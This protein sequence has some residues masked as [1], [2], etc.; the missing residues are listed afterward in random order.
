MDI[1]KYIELSHA[2]R[3]FREEIAKTGDNYNIFSVLRIKDDEVSHSAFL[4]D[5]LSPKGSHGQG[6]LFLK[7]FFK[8][9]LPDL[10]LSDEQLNS[11]VS[12]REYH[13][14][15][16]NKEQT[17]GGF[18][19]ILLKPNAGAAIPFI[20]IEN[21]IYAGDQANQLLRYDHYAKKA[22]YGNY[23]ILY[24]TLDGKDASD[25]SA[26]G[27]S[28]RRISYRSHIV[29]WL[30]KCTE[31]VNDKPQINIVITQYLKTLNTLLGNDMKTEKEILSLLNLDGKSSEEVIN[32]LNS[33][34]REV[35]ELLKSMEAIFN[36]KRK[37]W[38]VDLT[39]SIA[40]KC[41][42]QHIDYFCGPVP[43]RY[44]TTGSG[45]DWPKAGIKVNTQHFGFINVM[46]DYYI[47][48]HELPNFGIRMSKEDERFNQIREQLLKAQVIS[49]KD[50]NKDSDWWAF[51][52][53][54][55]YN[56]MEERVCKLIEVLKKI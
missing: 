10:E 3:S 55:P 2:Y 16:I 12:I 44:E 6:V 39:K 37:A 32:A 4:A 46:V 33:E 36:E 41:G 27:V 56:E 51:S 13:I 23:E 31:L 21:K 15:L 45:T 38:M 42:E 24:L 20:I 54:S 19:D 30:R 11:Y 9:V 53:H 18:I 49:I 34:C 25:Y 17:E 5:L 48:K 1:N 47:K 8:Y 50:I 29:P 52:C 40:V 14:G 28:Y 22:S 35:G 26:K 43:G 7:E